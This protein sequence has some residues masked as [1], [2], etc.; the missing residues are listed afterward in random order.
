MSQRDS[1]FERLRTGTGGVISQLSSELMRSPAF[2]KAVQQALK[3]RELLDQVVARV[4]K[5]ADIPTRSEFQRVVARIESLED[6]LARVKKAAR[7]RRRPAARKGT[8]KKAP[9]A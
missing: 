1:V 6:E 3:G 8:R 2:V 4:R 9:S 7:A 5:Q